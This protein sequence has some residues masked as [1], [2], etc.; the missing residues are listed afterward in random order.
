VN[1]EFA[2]WLTSPEVTALALTQREQLVAQLAWAQATVAAN[3]AEKAHLLRLQESA[4]R[5][6]A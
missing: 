5:R 4:Q 2:K 1:P 3:E 6:V